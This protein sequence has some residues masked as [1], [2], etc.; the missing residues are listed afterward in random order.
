MANTVGVLLSHS[1]LFARQVLTLALRHVSPGIPKL[2]AVASRVSGPK[3]CS[4]LA[5]SAGLR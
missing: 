5:S 2:L 3:V 4:K 1:Q